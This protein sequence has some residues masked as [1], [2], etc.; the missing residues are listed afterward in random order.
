MK[1]KSLLVFGSDEDMYGDIFRLN[2]G[3]SRGMT[4]LE[5]LGALKPAA[6]DVLTRK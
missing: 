5:L 6:L 1:L 4:A 3:I 2:E